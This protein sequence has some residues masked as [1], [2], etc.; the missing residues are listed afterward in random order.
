MKEC[1][2]FQVGQKIWT[3]VHLEN[4]IEK[5]P[6]AAREIAKPVK[7]PLCKHEEE[8]LGEDWSSDPQELSREPVWQPS[9]ASA[10]GSQS[11]GSG[12]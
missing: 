4:R 1:Y 3:D 5:I 10:L 2:G 8:T 11:Q 12:P 7:S 9:A 6:R